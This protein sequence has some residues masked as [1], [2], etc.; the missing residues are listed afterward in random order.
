M[1]I[2]T[3]MLIAPKEKARASFGI[4]LGK[5]NRAAHKAEPHMILMNDPTNK[6]SFMIR[7]MKEEEF[8]KRCHP[9]LDVTDAMSKLHRL[10]SDNI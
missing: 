10:L 4:Y 3:L 5:S 6:N 2:N 1:K 8:E 9:L 7:L